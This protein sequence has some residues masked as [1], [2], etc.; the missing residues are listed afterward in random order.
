MAITCFLPCRKGSERVP[1]KNIRPI[2]N[3]R[4][5]LLEIK[6]AQLLASKRIDHIILSTNDPDIIAYARTVDDPRLDIRTR[7]DELSSSS[8]STD[9]LI[10][11]AGTQV[12]DG[13]VLWT[14]VTSPFLA[15]DHYDAMIERYVDAR[16]QG[17]DSLMSVNELRGFLWDESGPI[18]YDRTVEKWPRTQTLA[19]L[20]EINSAVFLAPV[21]TYRSCG[22]RI[23]ERPYKY[24]LDKI[25]GFDID[26]EDDFLMAE[27]MLSAGIG[28]TGIET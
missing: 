4:F 20:Y 17:Y 16:E 27:A 3:Y 1:R 13:D 21:D 19:P 8:T 25:Q 18:N 22:D 14:H 28:K 11:F 26:W 2:A 9:Q 5:G 24:V 6:L 23:G 10:E 15:A 7:S 12:K